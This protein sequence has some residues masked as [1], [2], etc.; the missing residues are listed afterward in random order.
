M[1]LRIKR[2]I[3][4]DSA[5]YDLKLSVEDLMRALNLK[6]KPCVIELGVENVDAEIIAS[7]RPSENDYAGIDIDANTKNGQLYYLGN[8]EL[9]NMD[10][11]NDIVARLYAGNAE[12]ETDSPIALAKHSIKT[13]NQQEK[14]TSPDSPTKIVYVDTELAQ[15]R[16]WENTLTA[17]EHAED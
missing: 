3:G 1:F 16:R 11:E 5:C 6:D 9:P 10:Y 7:A 2:S 12:Y 15:F 13:E 4:P 17:P 8:F 14:Y